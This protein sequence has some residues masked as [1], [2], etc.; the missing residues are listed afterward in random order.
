MLS[1]KMFFIIISD[2]DWQRISSE[3]VGLT[4]VQVIEDTA[5]CPLHTCRGDGFTLLHLAARNGY[6]NMMHRLL[7]LKVSFVEC[8]MLF[9][10]QI[11]L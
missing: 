3:E 9:I 2:K 6:P 7:S 10:F 1:I 8:F 11:I 4:I 5:V